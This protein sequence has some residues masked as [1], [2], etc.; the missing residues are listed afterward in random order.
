MVAAETTY[1]PTDASVDS[2]IV[3][4]KASNADIFLVIANGKF[5]VQSLTKAHEIGWKPQII[6]PIGSASVSGIMKPR[7]PMSAGGTQCHLQ[8][9][10][11][12]VGA[13]YTAGHVLARILRRCGDD[14]T[15]ENIMKQ[16]NSLDK[17]TTSLLMPDIELTSSKDDHEI[18]SHLWLQRFD[19]NAWISFG[20]ATSH[21]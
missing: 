8:Q 17:F 11:P 14:L 7:A 19:G 21:A 12:L 20:K 1:E 2:Q 5:V 9:A 18:F 16:A 15:R 3:T 13:G 6:L 10:D 4:L